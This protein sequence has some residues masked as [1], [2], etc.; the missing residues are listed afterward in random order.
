MPVLS[1]SLL[2]GSSHSSHDV[3]LLGLLFVE[4][5]GFLAESCDVSVNPAVCLWNLLFEKTTSTTR[6]CVVCFVRCTAERTSLFVNRNQVG[7]EH[8]GYL[9]WT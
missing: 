6:K 4:A 7:T 2:T 5:A 3:R 9:F 1:T 8:P